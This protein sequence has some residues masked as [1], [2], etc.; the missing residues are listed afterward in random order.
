MQMGKPAQRMDPFPGQHPEQRGHHPQELRV[1]AAIIP[2]TVQLIQKEAP[3][4]APARISEQ[5]SMGQAQAAV[6][7]SLHPPD[8]PLQ[9]RFRR[10][11]LTFLIHRRKGTDDQ[12]NRVFHAGSVRETRGR[13]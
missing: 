13:C 7:E 11:P 8:G 12:L 1:A 5:A 6:L 9:G 3:A 2:I 4:W 10:P